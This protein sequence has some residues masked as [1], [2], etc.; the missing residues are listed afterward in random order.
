MGKN[1]RLLI[2]LLFV[3]LLL[4][5]GLVFQQFLLA[6]FILPAATVAWLFLRIFVLSIGQQV[7]WW[8]LILLI[9]LLALIRLFWGAGTIESYQ[10]SD[11]NPTLDRVSHWR[12]S[13][14]LDLHETGERNILKRDLMWLLTTLHTTRQHGSANYEIEAAINQHQIPVPETIYTFLCV[15]EPMAPRQA[16][17]KHPVGSIKQ[18]LR[19]IRLAPKKWIR[20]WSGREAVEYYRA[21]DEVLILLETSLEMKYDDE[22]VGTHDH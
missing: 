6:N 5:L 13:I 8:L 3:G 19:S 12:T 16:F 7:Y 15:H 11:S 10:L 21:I 1:R 22:S 20:R 9:V 4:F 2:L 18:T 17:L 14:L